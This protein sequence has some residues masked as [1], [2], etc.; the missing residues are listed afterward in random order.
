MKTQ[1]ITASRVFQI[2]AT[3]Y[4]A[5]QGRAGSAQ[6]GPT[7]FAVLGT[8]LTGSR[9]TTHTPGNTGAFSTAAN[10]GGT[11]GFG[12]KYI[13]LLTSGQGTKADVTMTNI[14]YIVELSKSG[15]PVYGS[16]YVGNATTEDQIRIPTGMFPCD[17]DR[18]TQLQIR[19]KAS[20][21]AEAQDYSVMLAG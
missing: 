7:Q 20:G 9:G 1:S 19:A 8:N 15:G 21:T 2:V 4:P 12:A 11:T 17:I 13:Q 10:I 3:L 14:S 16:W 6:R 18:G 5:G